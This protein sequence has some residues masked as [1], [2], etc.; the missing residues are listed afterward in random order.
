MI[1]VGILARLLI[2]GGAVLAVLVVGIG[3]WTGTWGLL[4][5]TVI[6]LV[7]AGIGH[8]FWRLQA[9]SPG[10]G[11]G[12]GGEGG[13]ENLPGF[14]GDERAIAAVTA[15]NDHADDHRNRTSG[16]APDSAASVPGDAGNVPTGGSGGTAGASRA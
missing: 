15:R 12:R 7:P 9:I 13:T 11:A 14:S 10:I 6:G 3:L 16:P 2:I 4:A 1:A 5:T 8:D